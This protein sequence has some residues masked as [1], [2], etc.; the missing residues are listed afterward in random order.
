MYFQNVTSK[1][2]IAEPIKVSSLRIT[3]PF[4]LAVAVVVVVITLFFK[5]FI[6]IRIDY[7]KVYAFLVFYMRCNP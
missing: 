1:T 2:R 6:Y 5:E 7:G 3:K 4:R